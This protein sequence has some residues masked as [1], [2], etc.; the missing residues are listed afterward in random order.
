[1][2]RPAFGA[3]RTR[4]CVLRSPARRRLRW[5]CQFGEIV[6]NGSGRLPVGRGT[7]LERGHGE[8]PGGLALPAGGR[9]L[10]RSHGVADGEEDRACEGGRLPAPPR[11]WILCR[12]SA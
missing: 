6:R 7:M 11:I 4:S 5:G 12:R 2:Q 3:E 1:M 10:G 8:A 9:R